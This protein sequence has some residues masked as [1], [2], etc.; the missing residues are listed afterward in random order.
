MQDR[1]GS[2]MR[3]FCGDH[4]MILAVCP[5]PK[6]PLH[7]LIC[8]NILKTID[9]T[10]PFMLIVVFCLLNGTARSGGGIKLKGLQ[11]IIIPNMP[12]IPSLGRTRSATKTEKK[13]T[14][15]QTLTATMGGLTLSQ[16]ISQ[17]TVSI[18]HEQSPCLYS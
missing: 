9:S 11:D 17:L 14:E 7:G 2:L 12:I 5:V 18:F 1:P 8:S 10:I 3:Y 13:P 16:L 15:Y 4:Y 6:S